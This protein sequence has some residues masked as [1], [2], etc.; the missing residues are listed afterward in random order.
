MGG[1]EIQGRVQILLNASYT[2]RNCQL[3]AS[4]GSLATASKYYSMTPNGLG[5]DCSYSEGKQYTSGVKLHDVFAYN[6]GQCCNACVATDGCTAASFHT[7]SKDH[8]GGFGPQEWEGFGIHIT[9]V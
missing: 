4:K 3:Y 6:K 9:D 8:S 1:D 2:E 7:S 5:K